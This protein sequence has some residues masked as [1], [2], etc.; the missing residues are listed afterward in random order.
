MTDRARD[1]QMAL[2]ETIIKSH[3]LGPD[4]EGGGRYSWPD[5]TPIARSM[6]G[7][8]SSADLVAGIGFLTTLIMGLCFKIDEAQASGEPVDVPV[9]LA[10]YSAYLIEARE[11]GIPAVPPEGT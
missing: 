3:A 10:Y 7:D 8:W 1:F 11:A 2:A 4:A 9:T 5:G 6:S